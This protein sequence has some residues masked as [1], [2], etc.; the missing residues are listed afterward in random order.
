[1]TWSAPSTETHPVLGCAVVVTQAVESVADVDPVF[2]STGDKERAL[3]DLARARDLVEA[4]WLRVVDSADDVAELSGAKDVAAWLAANA[5]LDRGVAVGAQRLAASLDR[6]WTATGTA[7]QSG[8]V[9]V[10]QARVITRC[11]DDLA[12]AG[13]EHPDCAVSPEVLHLAEAK[14]VELAQLHSPS[15]LRRL[16]EKILSVVAPEVAEEAERRQLEAAERKSSAATRLFIRRRGDGSTDVSARVPD[17]VAARLRTYLDAFTSPRTDQGPRSAVLDPATGTKLPFDRLQGEAFCALLEC[18]PADVMPLH[19]GSATSVVVTIDFEKLRDGVGEGVTLD[20]TRVTAEHA[21]KLACNAGIIPAVLGTD[22]EV[23]DLGRRSRFFTKAQRLKEALEHPSCRA[24]GCSVPATFCEAHHW[25][26]P[27]SKGG[28][29]DRG[30]IKLL[31]PWH[32]HRA[33]DTSYLTKHHPD[34]SV[35][36][37]KRR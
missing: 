3:V 30:D 29:S 7:V 14:L 26:T 33:H 17:A 27:W 22:S 34:G 13:R 4:L 21:R 11:L 25:R 10:P 15:E 20:G 6:D 31:C 5:K 19:G 12:T 1:M 2:M 35:R 36:F 28:T 9:S 23:L 32:H 24:H 16:G 8:A 37:H 18:L